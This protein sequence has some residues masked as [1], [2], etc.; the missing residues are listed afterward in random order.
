MGACALALATATVAQTT[1]PNLA[2]PAARTG[3]T[4]AEP[5]R[6]TAATDRG[7]TASARVG[8][9][10]DDV[11][12]ARALNLQSA[13]EARAAREAIEAYQAAQ[14]DYVDELERWRAQLEF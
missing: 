6:A 12:R 4:A 9:A 3:T 11:Q 13:E 8:T 14:R 7:V 2:Q 1:D 10:E 5:Q